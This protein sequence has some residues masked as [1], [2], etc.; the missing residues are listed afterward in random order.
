MKWRNASI[1]ERFGNHE[2]L[3]DASYISLLIETIFSV[4]DVPVILGLTY[5]FFP[6]Y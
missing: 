5:K 6:Q 2:I 1:Q 4:N 3:H